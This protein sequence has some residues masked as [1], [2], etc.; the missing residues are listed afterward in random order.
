MQVDNKHVIKSETLISDN[1]NQ[2]LPGRILKGVGGNYQ[3]LLESGEEVTAKPRGIL[4]KEKVTPYPGDR[5]DLSFTDDETIQFNIDHIQPRQSFL[6]RPAIAN[7]DLMIITCSAT[8][9][10]PDCF[11]LDKLIIICIKAKVSPAIC[12]TKSEL[13]PQEA[14]ILRNRYKKTGIPLF[15]VGQSME[16]SDDIEALKDMIK[17]RMV[18]FA[19][20]SGVGKSTLLNR[21]LDRACMNTGPVSEKIGRGRHTTRHSQIFVH[22]TGFLADT[23]G[24]SSLELE[25]LD[26]TGEDVLAGFPEIMQCEGLCKFVGCRHIGETGCAID[27]N[28]VDPDRLVRYRQFRKQMDAIQPYQMKKNRK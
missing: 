18:S 9:P 13:D 20:Q 28:A 21:I 3:I 25:D 7:L 16:Y 26:V 11:L 23:P 15:V 27:E 1:Q 5:V 2:T 10:K 22:G 6:I 24:F 17:G 12:I 19:G 14:M 8:S 4:R